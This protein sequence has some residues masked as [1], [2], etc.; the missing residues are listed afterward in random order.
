MLS[1]RG[2]F[3][4]GKDV[5]HPDMADDRIDLTEVDWEMDPPELLERV[6]RA[7]TGSTG[8][9]GETFDTHNQNKMHYKNMQGSM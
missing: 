3:H 1:G 8:S 2:V 7:D 9:T 4:T 5:D 6:K